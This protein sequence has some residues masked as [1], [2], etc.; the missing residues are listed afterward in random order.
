[1]E[2]EKETE[3]GSA[4]FQQG[5][6]AMAANDLQSAIGFLEQSAQVVPHF[7]T[8][9]LLGE[10]LLKRGQAQDALIPL[11]KAVE[12]GNKPYRSLYLLGQALRDS[13]KRAGRARALTG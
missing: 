1:M 7:K 10:C 5:R 8:F 13:G 4:L 3:R 6:Q 11:R 9:E 2:R 12:I